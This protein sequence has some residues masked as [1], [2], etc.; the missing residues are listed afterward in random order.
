MCRRIG[1]LAVVLVAC[2]EQDLGVLV[3]AEPF[4]RPPP[5]AEVE[6]DWERAAEPFVDGQGSSDGA[7]AE[8]ATL[9]PSFAELPSPRFAGIVHGL[10]GFLYA[11][12][13]RAR[14]F[15]RID[16]DAP[17]LAELFGPELPDGEWG[18]AAVSTSGVIY[19]A[20]LRQTRVF[21]FD[22]A[23]PNRA[24]FVGPDYASLSA[25]RWRGFV[26]SLD[27]RLYALP[28]AAGSVLAFNPMDPMSSELLGT[29]LTGYDGGVLTPDGTIYGI[30]SDSERILAV[31]GERAELEGPLLG[32]GADKFSAGVLSPEGDVFAFGK[33]SRAVLSF[34]IESPLNPQQRGTLNGDAP[35]FVRSS[36]LAGDGRLYAAP[37]G[38]DG[39][40]RF[41]SRL[42]GELETFATDTNGW[43]GLM[44]TARGDLFAA[45]YT[46]DRL[47]RIQPQSEPVPWASV[48]SPFF[49]YY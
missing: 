5:G 7:S 22:P 47:L 32:P 2:G 12:P 40:V 33:Q 20:P 45:P 25:P 16:P 9:G 15:L 11:V 24:E 18:G 28:D 26:P 43:R 1:I 38:A 27:G 21:A 46:A 13:A 10:D 4:G 49:N 44:L 14:R 8:I 29:S 42:P 35:Y 39:V 17:E 30:P 6:L 48:L 31:M 3:G 36:A 34:A 23:D 41:D 19:L 37:A